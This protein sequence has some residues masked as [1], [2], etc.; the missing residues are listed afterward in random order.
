MVRSRF[1]GFALAALVAFHPVA[2]FADGDCASQVQQ[3]EEQ[4]RTQYINGMSGLANNNFSQRQGSYSQLACLDKFMQGNMDT[5]FRPPQLSGLLSQVLS[6][7][8]EKA[9]S[10]MGGALGNATNLQG[11]IGSMAGGGINIQGLIGSM[12]GGGLNMGSIAGGGGIVNLSQTLGMATSLGGG[13]A[14]GGG[15]GGLG[16]IIGGLT[17]GSS[18]SGGSGGGAI[19]GTLNQLL[20]G[21]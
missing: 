17:G 6:F 12:A 13:I 7:A 18:W 1:A 16:G 2:A 11:L 4:S 10:S 14:G 3:A 19:G 20:K 15:S 8:C 9:K 21:R 5:L